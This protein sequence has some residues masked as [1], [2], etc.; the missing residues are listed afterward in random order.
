[1]AIMKQLLSEGTMPFDAPVSYY[2]GL[3][4]EI[5]KQGTSHR[6]YGL[7]GGKNTEHHNA[8]ASHHEAAAHAIAAIIKAKH[9][10][11]K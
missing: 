7:K 11:P 2:E 1:M 8:M 10:G 4:K 6:F 5:T 3:H 9:E